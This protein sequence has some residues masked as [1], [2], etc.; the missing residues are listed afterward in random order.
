VLAVGVCN[1]SKQPKSNPSL[2]AKKAEPEPARLPV[3]GSVTNLKGFTAP[4]CAAISINGASAKFSLR[5]EPKSDDPR[6]YS[7]ELVADPQPRWL[8]ASGTFYIFGLDERGGV[9]SNLFDFKFG[10]EQGMGR[11]VITDA[12]KRLNF[13]IFG[14]NLIAICDARKA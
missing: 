5:A 11:L 6:A 8:P 4:T 13:W 1:G 12:A 3:T 7:V 9:Y 2:R 14:D 10:Q